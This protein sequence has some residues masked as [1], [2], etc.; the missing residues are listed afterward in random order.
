MITNQVYE[1]KLSLHMKL[2]IEQYFG[3]PK[4]FYYSNY[5]FFFLDSKLI[6]CFIAL[7][8]KIH[9]GECLSIWQ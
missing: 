2:F 4:R 6:V 9:R 3:A 8:F 7:W 5:F 1:H